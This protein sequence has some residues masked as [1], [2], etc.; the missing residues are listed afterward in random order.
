MRHWDVESR[1]ASRE[2]A[3]PTNVGLALL[4]LWEFGVPAAGV[5]AY[6]LPPPSEIV[7]AGLAVYP[8]LIGELLYSLSEFAIG[9][10]AT[11]VSGYLLALLMFYSKPIEMTVYPYVIVYRSI[12]IVTL[13]PM[14]IIWFGFGFNS[15][16]VISYLISFFPMVVNTL[17]G[18]KSTDDERVEMLKSFSASD[19]ELFWNVYRYSSLPTVFAGLKISTILAFTGVIVGE[20]LIGQEGIGYLIYQYNND[21]A[22]AKMFAGIF[23]VSLTQLLFYGGIVATER[24]LVTW[25]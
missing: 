20:F 23:T 22:T 7:A 15:I 13:L 16:V 5:P 24:T 21:F 6:I 4:L 11:V 3:Y 18:F 1:L 8:V 12:P 9:F 2:V 25:E 19:R 14:F 17:S 10:G